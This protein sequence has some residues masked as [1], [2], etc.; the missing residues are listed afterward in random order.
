[1]A[2]ARSARLA[3]VMAMVS[4]S[5]RW[6][7][8]PL[9]PRSSVITAH[10]AV[11]ADGKAR[12]LCEVVCLALHLH[13][14]ELSDPDLLRWL[15]NPGRMKCGVSRDLCR[16]TPPEGAEGPL[17]PEEMTGWRTGSRNWPG[18]VITAAF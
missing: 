3:T 15:A 11:P 17:T 5:V 16:T 10:E 8:L 14:T 6:G 1:M 7:P 12:Y 2:R 9:C 4:L 13:E 18:R